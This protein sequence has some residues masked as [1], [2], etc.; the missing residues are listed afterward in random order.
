MAGDLV[1][2]Y[3]K[4]WT[5]DLSIPDAVQ[6][7]FYHVRDIPYTAIPGLSDPMA[8]PEL[9]LSIGRGSCTPKHNLLGRMLAML[10]IRVR[11]A[12]YRFSWNDKQISYPAQLREQAEILPVVY[13]LAIRAFLNN[14]WTLLDA[15][16][17]PPLQKVGFPA[18]IYW[19]GVSDCL[20][21][22][23]PLPYPDGSMEILHD[24]VDERDEFYQNQ[25]RDYQI[26]DVLALNLFY[27]DLNSWLDSVRKT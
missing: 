20:I 13:H 21:A 19:D 18:N 25:A 17:D 15:T 5:E 2:A 14:R 1:K 3:M 7:I 16:W 22:V 23:N 8:G 26:E 24:S 11:Y 6:S 9:L 10:G 12:S 27:Q 4:E